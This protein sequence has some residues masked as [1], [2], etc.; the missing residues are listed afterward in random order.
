MDLQQMT[1]NTSVNFL[2]LMMRNHKWMSMFKLSHLW[3]KR[4]KLKMNYSRRQL[5]SNNLLRCLRNP[6]DLLFITFRST[7]WPPSEEWLDSTGHPKC[8]TIWNW[9]DK[10]G[11][12]SE[13]P[14]NTQSNLCLW[15]WDKISPGW[16]TNSSKNMGSWIVFPDTQVRTI[17]RPKSIWRTACL[18]PSNLSQKIK[19]CTKG[20]LGKNNNSPTISL[21]FWLRS[22]RGSWIRDFRKRNQLQKVTTLFN[23]QSI[24]F[25]SKLR[26]LIFIYCLYFLL[27][28]F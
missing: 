5:Q 19:S 21:R 8:Q 16:T 3:Q 23:D 9:Q 15:S 7:L 20:E 2:F 26:K 18:R 13:T 28:P 11:R 1:T 25:H 4:K 22:R 27:I 17:T 24:S 10:C 12:F 6:K 14:K